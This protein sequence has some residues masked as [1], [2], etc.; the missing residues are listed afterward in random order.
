MKKTLIAMATASALITAGAASAHCSF[1]QSNDYRDSG[2]STTAPSHKRDGFIRV[3]GYQAMQSKPDIVDTAVSAGTFNTLV[4]AI[5]AAGLAETLKGDGPYTVFAPTDQAFAKL[6]DGTVEALLAD[7]DKLAQI[8]K[9]H[10]VPGRLDAKTVTSM[11]RLTTVE[12]SDLPVASI[13][14]T[15]TDIE[16]SNGVIHI[17]DEVLIPQS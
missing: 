11:T 15:A 8:L 16:T 7:P 5:Q 6:P 12:G 9:Y 13:Q 2:K 10:V 1:H 14:I 17:I 3:G 4:Q